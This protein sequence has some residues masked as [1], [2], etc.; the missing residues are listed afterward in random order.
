[1]K[2]EE[3]LI[4]ARVSSNMQRGD[5][6]DLLSEKKKVEGNFEGPQL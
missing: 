6:V 4:I 5:K 3:R 2:T 1:M